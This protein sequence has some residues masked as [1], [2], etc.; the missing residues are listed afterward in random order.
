LIGLI[1]SNDAQP[2]SHFV[3]DAADDSYQSAA[4]VI[5]FIEAIGIWVEKSLLSKLQNASYYTLMADEYVQM[6]HLGSILLLGRKWFASGSLHW[7][8]FFEFYRCYK[9]LFGFS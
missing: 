5:G 8:G 9:H 2:L 4:A 6:C 1:V 3:S 7:Y